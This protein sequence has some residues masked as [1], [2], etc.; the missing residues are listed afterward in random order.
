MFNWRRLAAALCPLHALL[1]L[2]AA[3]T[4]RDPTNEYVHA[5]VSTC[6]AVFG[7]LGIDFNQSLQT[8]IADLLEQPYHWF[9]EHPGVAR[10]FD[11]QH[12]TFIATNSQYDLPHSAILHE[13]IGNAEATLQPLRYYRTHFRYIDRVA[14][15]ELT[16]L[17]YINVA[18]ANTSDFNN[19]NTFTFHP[20]T[21]WTQLQFVGV[22]PS[23]FYLVYL[24]MTCWVI[25]V[26]AFLRL[27]FMSILTATSR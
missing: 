18:P 8:I 15:E 9:F 14:L 16:H 3:E 24:S 21:K 2:C 20:L 10:S 19:N 26:H 25:T 4:P 12:D 11:E 17:A 7:Q 23:P 13:M 1:F 6:S 5:H 22:V 27:R